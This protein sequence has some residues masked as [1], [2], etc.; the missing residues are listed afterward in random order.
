MRAMIDRERAREHGAKIK[1][2]YVFRDP[3]W[4]GEI[5]LEDDEV[6]M[7]EGADGEEAKKEGDWIGLRTTCWG[8]VRRPSV[9]ARR[10]TLAG[11]PVVEDN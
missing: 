3:S 11:V 8:K 4:S 1:K 7:K 2:P 6:L 9:P 10:T 5:N